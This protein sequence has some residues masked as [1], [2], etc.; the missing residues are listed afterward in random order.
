M[1]PRRYCKPVQELD[2]NRPTVDDVVA[3]FVIKA[4]RF[5]GVVLPRFGEVLF[6]VS[7]RDGRLHRPELS[8]SDSEDYEHTVD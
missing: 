7:I 2:K 6:R 5:A 3:L 8:I 1:S 4:N